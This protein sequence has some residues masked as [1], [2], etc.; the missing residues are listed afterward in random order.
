M[1][2]Q[3][4]QLN[5]NA[6]AYTDDEI[7]DKVN[8]A[9]NNITRAGSVAAAARPLVANEVGSAQLASGAAR[10]NLDAMADTARGYVR[11]VPSTGQFPVTAIQRSASG[12][13]EIDYDDQAV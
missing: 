13:L 6:Q 7:V 10:A 3:S 1:A 9:S 8:A 5:P 11:T 12:E 2:I 4:F